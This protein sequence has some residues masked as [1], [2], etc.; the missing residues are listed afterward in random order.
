MM[1]WPTEI[2]KQNKTKNKS[3]WTINF[4]EIQ[5]WTYIFVTVTQLNWVGKP[6]VGFKM[7]PNNNNKQSNK[8]SNAL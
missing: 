7:K 6:I 8:H 2:N 5:M 1:R 3:K 4:S